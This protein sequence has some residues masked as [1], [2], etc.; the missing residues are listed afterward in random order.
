MLRGMYNNQPIM[1]PTTRSQTKRNASQQC[2]SSHLIPD[3]ESIFRMA[4][5]GQ[6]EGD[7][8]LP[9]S[10]TYLRVLWW[11]TGLEE[12]TIT[13]DDIPESDYPAVY[14]YIRQK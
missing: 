14:A 12:G 6:L 5:R 2:T 1:P 4:H 9:T 10:C 13:D 8:W 11:G 3:F 7:D